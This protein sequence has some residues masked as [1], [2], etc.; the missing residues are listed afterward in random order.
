MYQVGG[1]GR[2][3]VTRSGTSVRCSPLHLVLWFPRSPLLS[4]HR[5][6]FVAP[7]RLILPRP[8]LRPLR[9]SGPRPHCL[10]R[11]GARLCSSR[12]A[13]RRHPSTSPHRRSAPRRGPS[14]PFSSFDV[15]LVLPPRSTLSSGSSAASHVSLPRRGRPCTAGRLGGKS[16]TWFSWRPFSNKELAVA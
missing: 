11:G 10:R 7:S 15:L 8:P 16:D 9:A 5:L 1:N 2:R 4:S 14:A 3:E 13:V 6:L 12:D